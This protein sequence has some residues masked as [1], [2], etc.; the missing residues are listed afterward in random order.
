MYDSLR[1]VMALAHPTHPVDVQMRTRLAITREGL[2]GVAPHGIDLAL[3]WTGVDPIAPACAC[4]APGTTA[5]A[6]ME[7]TARSLDA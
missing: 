7:T 6:A 1:D 2:Q 5:A 4:D 3:L